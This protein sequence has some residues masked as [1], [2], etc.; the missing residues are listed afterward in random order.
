VS[1]VECWACAFGITR[2]GRVQPPNANVGDVLGVCVQCGVV[3]CSYH[4]ER[5]RN[6]FKWVCFQSVARALSVAAGLDT[7]DPDDRDE[8]QPTVR[9]RSSH[10]FEQRY[11]IIAEATV[12]LRARWREWGPR[13]LVEAIGGFDRPVN[14]VLLADAVGVG[15]FLL[16]EVPEDSKYARIGPEVAETERPPTFALL[17]ERLGILVLNLP[18]RLPDG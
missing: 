7:P 3:G 14:P 6:G 10:E 17:P 2:V 4:A 8:V 13:L 12:D 18:E 5:D 16:S 9:L 11:P 1:P 15:Q